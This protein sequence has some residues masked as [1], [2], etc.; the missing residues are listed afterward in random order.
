MVLPRNQNSG[1][2]VAP[3]V[4]SR[5][6]LPSAPHPDYA[7]ALINPI[8]HVSLMDQRAKQLAA[9]IGESEVSQGRS[10][11]SGRQEAPGDLDPWGCWG[12][13]WGGAV[14]P[15]LW[16]PSSP[17]SP[18]R[19]APSQCQLVVWLLSPSGA[20]HCLTVDASPMAFTHTLSSACGAGSPFGSSHPE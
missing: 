20:V 5:R 14:R 15:D 16:T 19:T 18:A 12:C 10:G 9:L 17:R 7:E 13:G 3:G 4:L 1:E 8:K 6:P 11:A 2:G